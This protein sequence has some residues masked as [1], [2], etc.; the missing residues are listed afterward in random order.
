MPEIVRTK[1]VHRLHPYMGKFIP[2][3]VEVFLRKYRPKLVYDPFCGSGT[4]LISAEKLSRNWIGIDNSE[5]AIK[6]TKERLSK[7]EN[8]KPYQSLIVK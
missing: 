8:L 7:I 6:K 3:L 1:H 2:Q 4:T 5:M